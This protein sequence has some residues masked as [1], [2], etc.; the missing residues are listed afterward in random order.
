MKALA[1][2][3]YALCVTKDSDCIAGEM[4]DWKTK[5]IPVCQGPSSICQNQLLS[6]NYL[7]L[8]PFEG[9]ISF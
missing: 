8:N 4:A 3:F 1:E 7:Y 9:I 5:N 2:L 6:K